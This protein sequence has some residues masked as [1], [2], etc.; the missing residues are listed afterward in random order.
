ME[1]TFTQTQED[2]IAFNEHHLA[3]SP[4]VRRRKLTNLLTVGLL[5]LAIGAVLF[6]FS[7]DPGPFDWWTF[8]IASILLFLLYPA[9]YRRSSRRALDKMLSEGVPTT[10]E[11]HVRVNPVEIS[12]SSELRSSTVRWKGVQKITRE[13]GHAFVYVGPVEAFIVP[14]RAFASDAAFEEGVREIEGFMR[15]AGGPA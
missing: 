10:G 12:V 8:P 9:L 1:F 15:A 7:L 13:A 11:R 4:F 6:A 2:L 14:R 5:P 3:N